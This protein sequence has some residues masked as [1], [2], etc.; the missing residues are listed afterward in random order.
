MATANNGACSRR[1]SPSTCG[2]QKPYQIGVA[3]LRDISKTC[4]GTDVAGEYAK[5]ANFAHSNALARRVKW[6]WR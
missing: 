3:R 5:R 2:A 4:C 1:A 6:W